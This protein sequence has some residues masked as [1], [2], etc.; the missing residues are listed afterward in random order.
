MRFIC[1]GVSVT[2]YNG[3]HSFP[4]YIIKSL[5]AHN[6]TTA[7]TVPTKPHFHYLL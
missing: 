6:I 4:Q 1:T 3:E 2:A 5:K 7:Q